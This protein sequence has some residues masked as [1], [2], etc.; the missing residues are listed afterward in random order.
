MPDDP[1]RHEGALIA[2]GTVALTV[3]QTIARLFAFAFVV[4][5]THAFLPAQFGR[6]SIVSAL[7]LVVGMVADAGTTVAIT[8]H[9]SQHPE[10]S[11]A[12]LAGTAWFS[13]LLGLAAAVVAIL[14]AAA[15]GYPQVIVV[16][17]VIAAAGL[18]FDAVLTSVIGALDGRGRVAE[19]A[20]VSS[21]RVA[22]VAA[23]GL[24]AIA[25]GW[26]IRGA[27]VAIAIAPP[28]LLVGTLPL[29]RRWKVWWS[30]PRVDGARSRRLLRQ[31]MPFAIVGIINVFILRFDVLLIS[32][33]T[34]ERQ[35]ALYDV[36]TRSI[37]GVAYLGAVLGAPLMVVLSRR[38]GVG[39]RE[40][41]QR[42]MSAACR[43]SWVLGLGL[44]AVIIGARTPIISALFG[45]AYRDAEMALALLAL[46][47]PLLFVTG[48]Q[49]TALAAGTDEAGLV[50]VSLLVG[51]VTVGL[52]CIVVPLSGANGA[53]AVMVVVRI[54]ALTA[55][56]L[57]LRRS[58]HLV[59]P[60]PAPGAVIGAI[61]ASMA[62]S[63]VAL[64]LGDGW[65]ALVSAAGVGVVTYLF[66]LR[67]SGAVG[68]RDLTQLRALLS[69]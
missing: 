15:A 61:C 13:V 18:P 47:L 59:A 11:D 57:R 25:L 32:L 68:R 24:V 41:A 35:V 1:V 7:I 42:A 43:A 9:V 65:I 60:S 28:V 46:Q 22:L 50:R 23:G 2:R 58:T 27:I 39:D 48:L 51:L 37:E 29:A 53:A 63:A 16:D 69:R 64:A 36:A 66:V 26:G 56:A 17:V 52:D 30:R 34:N 10:D 19:R 67:V 44:A 55:F 33:L 45:H 3:G 8:K 40:G 14:F 4:A 62:A 38:L 31:A 21:G 54:V 20:W 49:G 6:Y 12:L 5:A